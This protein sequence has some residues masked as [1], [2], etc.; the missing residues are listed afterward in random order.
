[1][2]PTHR[3]WLEATTM[4][5]LGTPELIALAPLAVLAGL[6]VGAVAVAVKAATSRP[7]PKECPRCRVPVMPRGRG[8]LFYGLAIGFF[9][10]GLL[11]FLIP[12]VYV[13]DRCGYQV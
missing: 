6:I 5:G 12:K 11:L 7:I 10:V 1:M 4:L 2:C 9:P 13:C 3:I 8:C